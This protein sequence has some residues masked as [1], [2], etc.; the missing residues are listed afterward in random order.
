SLPLA[1]LTPPS[2]PLR[3]LPCSPD[4]LSQ[5]PGFPFP[6]LRFLRVLRVS[7]LDFPFLP[8]TRNLP[9]KKRRSP[10]APPRSSSSPKTIN[11]QLSAFNS[12]LLLHRQH[13]AKF[14]LPAH[15]PLKRLTRLRQRILLNHRPHTRL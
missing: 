1:G 10:T 7:A 4:L 3:I 14:R 9:T 11:F 8:S 2:S 13:H 15:H 5:P 6:S 12:L